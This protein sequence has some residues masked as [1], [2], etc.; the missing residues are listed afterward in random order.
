[1]VYR[2]YMFQLMLVSVKINSPFRRPFHLHDEAVHR[3]A[4]HA[5]LSPDARRDP[6]ARRGQAARRDPH[7]QASRRDPDAPHAR[8]V[9]RAPVGQSAP[10]DRREIRHDPDDRRRDRVRGHGPGPDLREAAGRRSG[11][12]CPGYASAC[13]PSAGRRTATNNSLAYYVTPSVDS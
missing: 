8:G 5:P 12:R 7:A 13:W 6:G 3:R 2:Q 1:M 10:G 4:Q 9:P 11:S